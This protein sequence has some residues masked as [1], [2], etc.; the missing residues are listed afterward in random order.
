MKPNE[1][2]IKE[3]TFRNN[4]ET[5]WP[6]DSILIQ[7]NGDDMKAS[8]YMVPQIVKPNEE[9]TI[10]IEMQ[11]P[12]LPGKYCAFFRFVHGDNHRFGQK[13]W[14]D[15]LVRQDEAPLISARQPVLLDNQGSAESRGEKSSLLNDESEIV[16]SAQQPLRFED[17]GNQYDLLQQNVAQP[18]PQV[19]ERE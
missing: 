18:V 8:S 4:G 17:L 6:Q 13:V 19:D 9:I 3:W 11:A 5:E 7:T 15:I 16:N 1:Y 10:Q 2:F 14:C 12:N